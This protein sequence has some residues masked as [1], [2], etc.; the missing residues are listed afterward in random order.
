MSMIAGALKQL[1]SYL[2]MRLVP[3][4]KDLI[5]GAR[6]CNFHLIFPMHP[7][8]VA[9]RNSTE[10]KTLSRIYSVPS[11]TIPGTDTAVGVGALW[12]FGYNHNLT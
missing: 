3:R 6:L 2:R 7:Q 8:S 12:I 5:R 4:G 1:Y 10:P 9:K 11:P